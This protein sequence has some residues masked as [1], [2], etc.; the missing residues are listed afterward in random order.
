MSTWTRGN[1]AGLEKVVHLNQIIR[2]R[3]YPPKGKPLCRNG[4]YHLWL[5]NEPKK[6]TCLACLAQINPEDLPP[7]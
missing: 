1:V 4:S 3:G 6:V 2:R 5:T 7:T